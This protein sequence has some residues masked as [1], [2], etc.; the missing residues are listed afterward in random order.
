MRVKEEESKK[1]SQC[2]LHFGKN[3]EALHAL[4]IGTEGVPNKALVGRIEIDS[5]AVKVFLSCT[6]TEA[7]LKTCLRIPACK[8]R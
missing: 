7:H 4:H 6:D 2:A 5:V 8:R 1:I 3:E